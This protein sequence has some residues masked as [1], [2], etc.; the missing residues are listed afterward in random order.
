LI[1]NEKTGLWKKVR[2]LGP[3]DSI[4]EVLDGVIAD[5]GEPSA[6]VPAPVQGGG[7]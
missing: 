1:G 6:Q 4:I 7:D 5:K 2:G 3:A